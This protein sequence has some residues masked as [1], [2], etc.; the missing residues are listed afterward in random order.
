MG[1]RSPNTVRSA[2]AGNY[3]APIDTAGMDEEMK[4]T[5]GVKPRKRTVQPAAQEDNAPDFVKKGRAAYFKDKSYTPE[6]RDAIT[7]KG[8]RYGS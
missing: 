1:R 8:K 7:K 3:R 2:R 5:L 6:Q 4:E